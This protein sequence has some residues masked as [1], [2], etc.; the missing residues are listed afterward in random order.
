MSNSQWQFVRSWG[1]VSYVEHTW[2]RNSPFCEERKMSSQEARGSAR[3]S[4]SRWKV[5]E[6]MKMYEWYKASNHGVSCCILIFIHLQITCQRGANHGDIRSCSSGSWAVLWLSMALAKLLS[7]TRGCSHSVVIP[8]LPKPW[9]WA[10]GFSSFGNP[11][12]A[13]GRKIPI[14]YFKWLA[15]LTLGFLLL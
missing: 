15:G 4:G 13:G 8:A 2:D 1:L 14:E 3:T 9:A 12:S 11:D 7:M 5:D 10:R 6:G